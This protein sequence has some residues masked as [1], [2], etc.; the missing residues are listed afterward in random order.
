MQTRHNSQRSAE[1]PTMHQRQ[2]DVNH[3][4]ETRSASRNH[5][6]PAGVLREYS[7]EVYNVYG[8]TMLHPSFLKPRDS[9]KINNYALSMFH[10]ALRILG[11]K[12]VELKE[13]ECL[14][15]NMIYKGFMRGY[16]S[17]KK[18]MVV[19][20]GTNALPRLADWTAPFAR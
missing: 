18:Q 7:P 4:H 20:A 6:P 1:L 10:C 2:Y 9:L 16:I 17:H 12:D 13:T 5:S 8:N 14:V 3:L 19:L 15:A 11:I